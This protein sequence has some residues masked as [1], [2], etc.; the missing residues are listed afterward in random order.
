MKNKKI[1]KQGS[2]CYTFEISFQGEYKNIPHYDLINEIG[3]TYGS[4]EVKDNQATLKLVLPKF[5]RDNNIQPFSII[6]SIYLEFIKNDCEKQLKQLLGNEINSKVKSIEC[7]ITQS[8]SGESTISD[9]LNL[10]SHAFLSF[11]RDNIKYVG[12]HKKCKLKEELHSVIIKKPHKY[13]IK[14]YNKSLQQKI[15]SPTQNDISDELLRIE[16][17]MVERTIKKLFGEKVALSDILTNKSL[18]NILNE[19]KRIFY[20]DI[21]PQIRKY[22]DSCYKHLVES[23]CETDSI[24]I[25]VAREREVIPD[26]KVLKKA[27]YYYQK[28]QGISN[29]SQRD[30]EHY[31][32]KYDLPKDV[33]LTIHDFKESCGWKIQHQKIIIWWKQ[34]II[35]ISKNIWNETQNQNKRLFESIYKGFNQVLYHFCCPRF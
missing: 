6:D 31:A 12:S 5:V 2:D 21:A 11:E 29:N 18:L 13:I 15:E 24:S 27:I 3:K 17:V 7:N 8:P 1:S 30:S 32:K 34:T 9:V 14:A 26:K 33:I 22:L 4:I 35:S 28:L 25:T 10:L 16:I 19:Y 23:L 20:D